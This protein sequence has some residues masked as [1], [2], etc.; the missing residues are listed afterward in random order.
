MRAVNRTEFVGETIRTALEAVAA[1]VP[2]WLAEIAR[3]HPTWA[4]RDAARCDSYRIPKG[5]SARE[6]WTRTVGEDG[7]ALLEAVH[8]PTTPG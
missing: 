7:F 5:D 2:D 3:Q 4:K 8:A 6:E 1:A